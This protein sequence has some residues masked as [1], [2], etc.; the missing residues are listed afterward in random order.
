M[1]RQDTGLWR[2]KPDVERQEPA[3]RCKRHVSSQ[4][5]AQ[6]VR[7]VHKALPIGID[8]RSDSRRPCS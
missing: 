8:G 5:R 7:V 6:D 2:K 1:E 3:M 4:W